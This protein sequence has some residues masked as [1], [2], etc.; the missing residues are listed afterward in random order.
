[1][2]GTKVASSQVRTDA[3]AMEQKSPPRYQQ[4]ADVLEQEIGDGRYD[5]DRRLPTEA[6]LGRR[7]AAS[8]HT[9]REALQILVAAGLIIRIQGN[10]TFVTSR[11]AGQFSRVVG[12]LNAMITWPGTRVEV[13]SE[14]EVVRD[15][16]AAGRLQIPGEFVGRAVTRRL[17]ADQPFAISTHFVAPE[18]AERLDGLG[19]HESEIDTVVG[20]VEQVL[21]ER[22][23]GG[24]QEIIPVVMRDREVCEQIECAAGDPVLNV[25]TLYYDDLGRYPML[26]DSFYNPDRYSY[27]T[28][29]RRTGQ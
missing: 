29:L 18:V 9:V 26:T 4:I 10:G 25:V 15:V 17:H 6:A 12:T 2:S 24:I 7:F 21:S 14:M 19:P 3:E 8:R 27:R 16:G 23:A 1:M 22:I 11:P 28:D 13:L 5:E 20:R